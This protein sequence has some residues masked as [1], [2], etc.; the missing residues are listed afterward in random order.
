MSQNIYMVPH[1]FTPVGDAAL[2]YAISLTSKVR[3]D[4]VVVHIVPD[5]S[6]SKPALQKMEKIVNE[7]NAPSYV[8]VEGKIVVGNFLEDLG[9]VA[10]KQN[11]QLIVMGTHGLTTSQKLFGSNVIKVV[12]SSEVPFLI[13]QKNTPINEIKRIVVPIDMTK[14]SLQITNLA[15][16]IANI[17]KAEIHVIAEDER[18]EILSRKLSNRISLVRDQF[19]ERGLNAEFNM[20]KKR[21]S[22]QTKVLEYVKKNNGDFI[23]FAYHSESLFAVFDTFASKLI[24]NDMNVPCLVINSKSASKLY[25]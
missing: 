20:V 4:I 2:K 12:T 15:G 25:F 23:A 16:D 22:F 3:V 17:F 18:D 19:E 6:K 9:K 1:D 5:K 11:A 14:E 7:C 24:V 21:G 13:V 8:K 10:K